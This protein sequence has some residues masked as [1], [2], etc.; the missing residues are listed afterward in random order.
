[1]TRRRGYIPVLFILALWAAGCASPGFVRGVKEYA[2]LVATELR[3][4][5]TKDTESDTATR[6]SRI[7]YADALAEAAMQDPVTLQA[8]ES[9]WAPAREPYGLYLDH[10]PKLDPD[11]R[12]LRVGNM[13]RLDR[14]IQAEAGRWIYGRR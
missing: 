2:P 7:A 11:E 6:A 10:D 4:Y 12:G 13:A 8:V 14:L 1:M 3:A 5:A 9:A